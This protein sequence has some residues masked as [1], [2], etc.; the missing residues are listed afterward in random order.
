MY[1]RCTICHI[2]RITKWAVEWERRSSSKVIYLLTVVKSMEESP[3]LLWT[4][5]VQDVVSVWR[6]VR[7][8]SA[9][10]QTEFT[11]WPSCLAHTPPA[12]ILPA[13]C[14]SAG[15]RRGD[16]RFSSKSRRITH[17]VVWLANDTPSV[18]GMFWQDPHPPYRPADGPN[19][20]VRH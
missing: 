11:L 16:G 13:L 18:W 19:Y 4:C 17:R 14:K 20:A 8:L 2:H 15:V 1:L 6:H 9:S 7:C 10:S 5:G 3:T 12:R